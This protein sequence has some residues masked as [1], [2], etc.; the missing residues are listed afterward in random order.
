MVAPA[1]ETGVRKVNLG[2]YFE[3]IGF[4]GNPRADIATLRELHIKHPCTIPFENL[5]TLLGEPVPLNIA[6]LEDKL[7]HRRRGGYCFEQN[8]LFAHVLETIGFKLTALAARVV[9]NP[10]YQNPRTH[11]AL[12]VE[13]SGQRWLCD[14]GFGGATLTAPLTFDIDVQQATP[15]EPFR[16]EAVGEEF[17]LQIRL[18]DRWRPVYR[19]DLQAQRAIDYEAMNFYVASHPGSQFRRV[20]MAGRPNLGGRYAIG[21]NQFTRYEAGTAVQQ[22][23]IRSAA[24]LKLLLAN[25][26]KIN[27][28]QHP[29]LE[30]LLERV[31]NPAEI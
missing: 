25:E 10:G 15:H 14:V 29:D 21:G 11:M 24:S 20:L 12:L 4:R 6:A 30:S 2:A 1:T 16:I 9:W 23:A 27:L 8:T 18:G 22:R 26:F 7:V 28:P 31:A 19:F 17:E 3:R 5:S 13:Q